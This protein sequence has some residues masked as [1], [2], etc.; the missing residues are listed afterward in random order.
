[1]KKTI[2]LIINIISYALIIV[3]IAVFIGTV[4]GEDAIPWTDMSALGFIILI[5][6]V[7]YIK[8]LFNTYFKNK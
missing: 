6:L 4:S 2:N 7:A 1:M 5:I 3:F 8:F